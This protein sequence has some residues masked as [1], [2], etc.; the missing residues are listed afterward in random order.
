MAASGETERRILDAALETLARQGAGK[1]SMTAISQ[2][3]HVSR[4][5]LYRYFSN[6]SDVLQA[7]AVHV[8]ENFVR[9]IDQAIEGEPA[10]DRRIEVVLAATVHYGDYQP[11]AAAVMRSEPGFTIEFLV[12][13]FP[14]YVE[15]IRKAIAPV[16]G[17]VPAVRS[18]RITEAEFANLITHLGVAGFIFPV[19]GTQENLARAFAEVTRG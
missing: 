9:A 18:G 10:L 16:V 13:T 17:E 7:V 19:N 15:V 11:V 5:T 14:H 4:R 8:G 1:V 3:A 12:N 6:S 2:A